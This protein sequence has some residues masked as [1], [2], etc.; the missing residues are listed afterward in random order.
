MGETWK[1]GCPVAL[2]DLRDVTVS[3]RGFDG[4]PTPAS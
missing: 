3:F 1:P 4:G 2:G